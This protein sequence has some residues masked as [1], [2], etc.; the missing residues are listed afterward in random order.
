MSEWSF[1]EFLHH[2]YYHLEH[3]RQEFVVYFLYWVMVA[4]HLCHRGAVGHALYYC[5]AMPVRVLGL[6]VVKCLKIKFKVSFIH[7]GSIHNCFL[8]LLWMTL[9]GPLTP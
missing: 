4:I 7:V 3:G 1:L 2:F 8:L 5:L 6:M 9:L